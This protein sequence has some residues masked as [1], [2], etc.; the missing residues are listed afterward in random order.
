MDT[1]K[2]LELYQQNLLLGD[3]IQLKVEEEDLLEG[4]EGIP[5]VEMEE[6]VGLADE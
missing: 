3:L 6:V 5:D 2:S 4:S 1:I